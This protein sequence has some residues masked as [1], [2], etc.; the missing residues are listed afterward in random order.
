MGSA[1]TA[2]SHIIDEW[3]GYGSSESNVNNISTLFTPEQYKMQG[4]RLVFTF[5]RSSTYTW[6]GTQAGDRKADHV[7]SGRSKYVAFSSVLK[8][9]T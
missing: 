3:T 9:V 4:D 7:N 1:A 8:L 2:P 5:Q 6:E